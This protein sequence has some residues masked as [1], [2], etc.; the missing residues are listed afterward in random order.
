MALEIPLITLIKSLFVRIYV[1]KSACG[2]KERRGRTHVMV[3]HCGAALNQ[4]IPV[5]SG[6]GRKV[7]LPLRGQTSLLGAL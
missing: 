6:R 1:L 5:W 3:A 2:A 4:L 7:S